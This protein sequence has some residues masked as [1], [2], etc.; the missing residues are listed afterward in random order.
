MRKPP[1]YITTR[2]GGDVT[3]FAIKEPTMRFFL[4]PDGTA[5][6]S[7]RRSANIVT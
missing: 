3:H 5:C 6:Y 4:S 2:R 1:I 7:A